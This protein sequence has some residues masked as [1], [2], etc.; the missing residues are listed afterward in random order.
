MR[1]GQA[2]RGQSAHAGADAGDDFPRD[3]LASEILQFLA[4]AAEDARIAALEPNHGLAAQRGRVQQ[5]VDRFLPPRF[6]HAAAACR[7]Q[8]FHTRRD[9]GGERLRR[10]GRRERRRQP[11]PARGRRAPSAGPPPRGPLPSGILC[12]AGHGS[13]PAADVLLPSPPI[14]LRGVATPGGRGRPSPWH[15]LSPRGLQP[16]VGEPVGGLALVDQ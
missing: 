15:S 6:R 11:R 2:D 9:R 1:Q 5:A 14:P 12:R 10:R 4:A 3:A 16:L 13:R 8:R 7:R